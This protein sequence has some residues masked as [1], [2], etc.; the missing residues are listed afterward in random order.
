[1]ATTKPS[2]PVTICAKCGGDVAA[3][4][5]YCPACSTDAGF[6]NV[7]Y[8]TDVSE[9]LALKQRLE[10]AQISVAARGC[11]QA[12]R[13]FIAAA[14][15]SRAI[16]SRDLGALDTLVKSE[17][18]LYIGFHKQVRSGARVAEQ[19][20]WDHGR[21]A[22]ESTV[23]PLFFEHVNYAALSLDGRGLAAYGEYFISLKTRL[24]EDRS[25]VFEENPFTFCRRHRIIAGE[26]APLGYRAPWASRGELAG[27]K[28]YPKINAVTTKNEYPQ[29]LLS[30]GSGTGDGRASDGD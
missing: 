18:A 24:I 26:A 19:N 6:P 30:P 13:D 23:L 20:Q 7:R 27:A 8:A 4:L 12:W 21:T 29:I 28:L 1:M 22:A 10:A 11:E 16:L 3:H 25:S 17:N 14:A 5:R 15:D 2:F 9:R